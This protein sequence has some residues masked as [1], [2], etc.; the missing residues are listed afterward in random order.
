MHE[1]KLVLVDE[2][3]GVV[4]PP[5]LLENLGV[6]DGGDVL[7]L[8]GVPSAQ[9]LRFDQG[10]GTRVPAYASAMGKVLLA[11]DPDPAEDVHSV[12][13]LTKLTGSTITSRSVLS[14]V[15]EETRDRGWAIN[16]EEREPSVRTV[17]VPV[18]AG[19]GCAVAAVAV[20]GPSSRMTDDRITKLLPSLQAAATGVATRLSALRS[21]GLEPTTADRPV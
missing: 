3:V 1:L 17:A 4:L 13:R 21:W 20:Q 19:D 14:R 6:R 18:R 9:N 16:D 2:G 11:F 10:A 7:V 5:E 15:L 8:L 12:P